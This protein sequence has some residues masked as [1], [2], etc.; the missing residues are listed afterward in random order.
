MSLNGRMNRM[1]NT[2]CVCIDDEELS[3]RLYHCYSNE[4]VTFSDVPEFF[5][6]LEEVCNETGFPEQK[7][8]Q[9]LFKKTKDK[10]INLDITKESR[11]IAPKDMLSYKGERASLMLSVYTRE[12]SNIQGMVY[13]IASDQNIEFKS[14]VE[15]INI[16]AEAVK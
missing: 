8:K 4:P 7:T 2:V 3:G 16:M 1:P 15:L 9:R 13:L 11:C 12:Y 10:K 6:L 14:E 5:K